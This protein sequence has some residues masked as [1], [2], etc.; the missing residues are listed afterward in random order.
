MV[1]GFE[2]HFHVGQ[3]H[4]ETALE[5]SASSA[6]FFVPFS[7]GVGSRQA[8]KGILFDL[9]NSRKFLGVKRSTRLTNGGGN[10]DRT[11]TR[12]KGCP[13]AG[14]SAMA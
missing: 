3:T 13:K 7:D 14:F 10:R 5:A 11:T 12:A 8:P 1:D 6:S 4:Y 9:N 2:I